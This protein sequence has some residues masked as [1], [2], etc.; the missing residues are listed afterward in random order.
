MTREQAATYQREY[1]KKNPEKVR[2]LQR[3]RYKR[4]SAFWKE[5]HK[6][7]RNNNR[8]KYLATAKR[9]RVKKMYG[10][11]LEE[12]EKVISRRKKCA[13]CHK[14]FGKKKGETPALDHDHKRR[15]LRKVI[16]SRC[17][18]GIGMFYDNPRLLRLAVKYLESC[19]MSNSRGNDTSR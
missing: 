19:N 10:L 1:R 9:T 13:L 2:G 15:K 8:E 11:T 4:N 16:H 12:Y 7:W 3:S 14:P 18:L 5:Y 17:N 6:N